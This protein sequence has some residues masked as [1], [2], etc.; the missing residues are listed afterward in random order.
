MKYNHVVITRPGGP[1]VL[2]LVADELPEPKAGEVR[3]KILATGVAFTDVMMR[4]G[5]YPGGHAHELLDHA[6][7]SGKLVLICHA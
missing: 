7:V 1:E 2:Q 6:E 4:E 3:V 5:V